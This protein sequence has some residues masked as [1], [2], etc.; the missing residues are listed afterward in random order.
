MFLKHRTG[1]AIWMYVREIGGKKR[2]IGCGSYLFF[3]CC[4]CFFFLAPLFRSRV[5]ACF[6]KL[7]L[8][9][10]IYSNNTASHGKGKVEVGKGR[11]KGGG[12]GLS[13]KGLLP[14]KGCGIFSH[15]A[16]RRHSLATDWREGGEGG[17]PRV[18]YNPHYLAFRPGAGAN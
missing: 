2:S 1:R 3:F 10:V 8:G 16:R 6:S 13:S 14:P 5:N 15:W 11:G 9:R 7:H 4:N 12:R 18:M 17:A